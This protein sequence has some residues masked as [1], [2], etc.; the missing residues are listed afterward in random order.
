MANSTPTDIPEPVV[1]IKRVAG[2]MYAAHDTEAYKAGLARGY[3]DATTYEACVLLSDTERVLHEKNVAI[4]ALQQN[5]VQAMTDKNREIDALA[6]ELV[7]RKGQKADTVARLDDRLL[8]R[9]EVIAALT[10]T[11]QAKEVELKE[12]LDALRELVSLKTMKDG[13]MSYDDQIEYQR[14]QPAAWARAR[15]IVN[16]GA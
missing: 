15:T 6:A 14:R 7:I 11:L 5:F 2:R 12:A 9:G 3:K 8:K 1:Y 13:R 16:P 4:E 10:D